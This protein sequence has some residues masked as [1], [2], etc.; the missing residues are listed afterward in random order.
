MNNS[1][2]P[3]SRI[4]VPFFVLSGLLAFIGGCSSTEPRPVAVEKPAEPAP[5]AKVEK[6]MVADDEEEELNGENLSEGE[7]PEP[8]D[9]EVN[10]AEE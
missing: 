4:I 3:K 5:V 10:N 2:T 7:N 8:S 9:D 6:D 1:P